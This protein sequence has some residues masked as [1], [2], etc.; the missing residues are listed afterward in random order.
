MH[1]KKTNE[2]LEEK[3]SEYWD[4]R[5]AS[6]SEQSMTQLFGDKRTAWENLIFGSIPENEPLDI[7]DI[8]T[9]PGFFSILA[10]LRGHKV[11][12]VDM[13]TEM[14]D[15]ARKNAGLNQVSIRFHQVGNRLP[16]DDESFDLI[17]SRDVTWTL[18]NPEEQLK[19]WASKLKKG[20]TMLYFDAEWYGYLNNRK[21]QA[22]IE[23]N[24]NEVL[25]KGGFIYGKAS[26]LEKLAAELPMTYKARPGWDIEFW[27]RQP[28]YE[29]DV[30]ENINTYVYNELEQLRYKLFPEFLITVKRKS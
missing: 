15:K 3:M 28:E 14:L 19:H 7:L 10:A 1:L 2:Y 21:K 11:T 20:G 5:S 24:R 27:S 16:S 26:H 9:G 4:E 12:A 30:R 8:G 13:N 6:Y 18:T 25:K 17:L 29:F 23:A 22:E